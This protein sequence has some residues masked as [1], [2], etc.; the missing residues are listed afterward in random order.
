MLPLIV[1]RRAWVHGG[2]QLKARRIGYLRAGAGNGYFAGLDRLPQRIQHAPVKFRQLIQKQHAVMR[3]RNLSRPGQRPTADKRIKRRAMMRRA[4]RALA[5]GF[6]QPDFINQAG[7]SGALQGFC[8]AERGHNAGQ[9][10]SQHGLACAGRANQ[11][12]VMTARCGNLQRPASLFLTNDI[13]QIF[14][15]FFGPI[16]LRMGTRKLALIL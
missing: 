5:P 14:C 11:Q 9:P 8:V 4:K 2:N 10:R 12:Q 7:D 1:T 16:L 13:A 6:L 3:Q 15:R